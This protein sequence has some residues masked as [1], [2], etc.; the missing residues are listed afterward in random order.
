[1]PDGAAAIISTGI[2]TFPKLLLEHAGKRPN[3]IAMREKE[4]GIWQSW[5]WAQ[6]LDEIRSMANGLAAMGFKHGDRLAIIGDN[7]PHL[8]WAMTAAQA[9]GG[10][11]VPIYQDSVVEEMAY[12]LNHAEVRF[13]LVEDQEQVH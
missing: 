6:A 4:F 1:M 11:P 10:V 7:R 13:A 9:L 5:S 2:D 8:Y 12:I 3:A